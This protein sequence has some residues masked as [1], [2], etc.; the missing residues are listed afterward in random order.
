VAEL[1][2]R[3]QMKPL[4]AIPHE[5]AA[6]GWMRLLHIG[7][8][9]PDADRRAFVRKPHMAVHALEL[10]TQVKLEILEVS[11]LLIERLSAFSMILSCSLVQ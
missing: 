8:L 10:N 11:D 4:A 5:T 1:S 2:R 7:C 6:F 3:F 9:N